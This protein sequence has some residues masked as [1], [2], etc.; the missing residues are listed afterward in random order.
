MKKTALPTLYSFRRC[1]YAMRARMALL[2]SG[3]RVELREIILRDKPVE[4]LEASPKGTVP[5]L[6]LPDGSVLEESLDI[7]LWSLGKNDPDGWMQGNL[8]EMLYLIQCCEDDFKPHLDRYKYANRYQGESPLEHRNK[9]CEFLSLLED[10]LQKHVFLF[11]EQV[12]LADMAI[13]TFVR[14]FANVDRAWF[15][16]CEYPYVREWVVRFMECEIFLSVMQKYPIWHRGDEQT[17]F[18]V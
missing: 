8:P 5:V 10:K 13:V 7:M 1:P 2:V 9:A 12:R 18:G 16:T 3:A 11:G 14:Q 15:D 17:I 6:L 4:M